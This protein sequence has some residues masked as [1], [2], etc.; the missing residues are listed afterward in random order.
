MTGLTGE[1]LEDL[2]GRLEAAVARA[3]ALRKMHG[4]YAAEANSYRTVLS[5]LDLYAS[6]WSPGS[7]LEP[8]AAS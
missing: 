8:V 7:V 1:Q 3:D 5:T 2:R 6:G 4:V